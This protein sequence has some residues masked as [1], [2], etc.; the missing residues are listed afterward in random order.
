M[1]KFAYHNARKIEISYFSKL[2]K[3]K[4]NIHR[5]HTIFTLFIIFF[6]S[7]QTNAR[8]FFINK[9][10]AK[11]RHK[12][13]LKKSILLFIRLLCNSKKIRVQSLFFSSKE[14][15]CD[16]LLRDYGTHVE[17][18]VSQS[19]PVRNETK[20]AATEVAFIL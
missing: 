13:R 20:R 7:L 19:R 6:L 18:V 5:I 14:T 10:D 12:A 16:S 3:Y 11:E 9:W 1:Y 2:C 17:G 4:K 15:T 8:Y